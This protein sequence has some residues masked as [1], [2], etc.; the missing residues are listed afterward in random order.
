MRKSQLALLAF[1]G[2]YWHLLAFRGHTGPRAGHGPAVPPIHNGNS[3]RLPRRRPRSAGAGS[4]NPT[5]AEHGLSRTKRELLAHHL[6]HDLA[7]GM[8]RF[9]GLQGARDLTEGEDLL[10]FDTDVA[11]VDERAD[12]GELA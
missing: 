7:A 10:D 6:Q 3:R 12:L 1:I 2:I 9:H 4:E 8:L 11:R 5:L